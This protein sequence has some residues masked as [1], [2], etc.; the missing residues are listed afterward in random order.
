MAQERCL[1]FLGIA[2]DKSR[3]ALKSLRAEDAL[4]Y[5]QA[6][7]VQVGGVRGIQRVLAPN[8]GSVARKPDIDRLLQAVM[9]RFGGFD[10]LPWSTVVRHIVAFQGRR[11]GR[12]AR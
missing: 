1:A 2:R 12:R 3:F 11:T 10:D 7:R 6:L 9:D 4:T 5:L 8:A